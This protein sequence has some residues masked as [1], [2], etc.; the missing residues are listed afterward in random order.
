MLDP[1]TQ[2]LLERVSEHLRASGRTVCTAESCTGGLVG[3]WLTEV[4]G[5]SD[6]FRGGVIAY[7]N[8]A[9]V[10]LLGVSP[11]T[12]AAHGAVSAQTVR[13]MAAGALRAFGCDLSVAVSGVAG[14][15]GGTPEK[16]VGTVFVCLYNGVSFRVEACRF[17]GTRA[18][19]RR[20]SAWKALE[21]ISEALEARA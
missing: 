18:A 19:V 8:E 7:S 17:E 14:P 15:G 2:A 13:E 21:M 4:A 1:T 9:K 11:G 6:Y 3:A 10:A 16:P 5:S 20:A 12:L